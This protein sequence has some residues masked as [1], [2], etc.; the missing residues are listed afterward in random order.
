LNRARVRCVFRVFHPLDAFFLP[1]PAHR[2]SGGNAP[3]IELSEGF[4]FHGPGSASRPA[5]PA[6]C[7]LK[8]PAPARRPTVL[9]HLPGFDLR[10]SPLL[11]CRKRRGEPDPPMSFS[12]SRGFHSL[13]DGAA[14]RGASSRELE[15]GAGGEPP[16]SPALRSLDRGGPETLRRELLPSWGSCTSSRQAGC[17]CRTGISL[18]FRVRESETP[19]QTTY[20]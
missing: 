5:L 20:N 8:R 3:G 12:P 4:P 18:Q 19:E 11:H 16:V 15:P 7:W 6:W 9:A 14:R 13:L 17:R 1:K 10:G 2:I